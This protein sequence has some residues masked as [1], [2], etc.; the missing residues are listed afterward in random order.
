[1]KQEIKNNSLNNLLKIK[2]FIF[3]HPKKLRLDRKKLVLDFTGISKISEK[4]YLN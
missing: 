1:M 4:M 2:N 3:Y